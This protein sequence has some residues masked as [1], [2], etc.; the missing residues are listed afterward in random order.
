MRVCHILVAVVY[1]VCGSVDL[2]LSLLPVKAPLATTHA[3]Q[4]APTSYLPSLYHQPPVKN[5]YL[6]KF[7]PLVLFGIRAIFITNLILAVVEGE[8]R[9]NHSLATSVLVLEG[10]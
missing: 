9:T 5:K 2:V 1:V 3:T 4:R 6:H 10:I 8:V 7:L